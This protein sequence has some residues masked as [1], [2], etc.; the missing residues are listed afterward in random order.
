M[1][2]FVEAT[3]SVCKIHFITKMGMKVYAPYIANYEQIRI[4]INRRKTYYALYDMIGATDIKKTKTIIGP[5]N[6]V[7]PPVLYSFHY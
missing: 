1:A 6:A 2:T 3:Q 5:G 4:Y 7:G